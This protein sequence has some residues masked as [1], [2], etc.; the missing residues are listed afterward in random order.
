MFFFVFFLWVFCMCEISAQ[1]IPGGLPALPDLPN[2]DA[3][4]IDESGEVSPSSQEMSWQDIWDKYFQNKF[5]TS[6]SMGEVVDRTSITNVLRARVPFSDDLKVTFSAEYYYSHI[7]AVLKK[8]DYVEGDVPDEIKVDTEQEELNVREAYFDWSFHDRASLSLGRQTLAWGQFPL[9][10]P[11][12]Y[13]LPWRSSLQSASANKADK[14]VPLD[15]AVL[16]LYPLGGIE[17]SLFYFNEFRY[18]PAVKE[19]IGDIYSYIHLP[20]DSKLDLGFKEP[21]DPFYAVRVASN[22]SWG[23]VILTYMHGYEQYPTRL[24]KVKTVNYDIDS[25]GIL[26]ENDKF[27]TAEGDYQFYKRDLLGF[28]ASIPFWGNYTFRSEIVYFQ[29]IVDGAPYGGWLRT[30]DGVLDY[31]NWLNANN[32]SKMYF[33][34]DNTIYAAGVDAVYDRWS[35][36]LYLYTMNSQL[37]EEHEEGHKLYEK[38]A[39]HEDDTSISNVAP[40]LQVARKCL[41]DKNLVLG[42][43]AGALEQGA[44][45]SLYC[46]HNYNDNINWGLSFDVIEYWIDGLGDHQDYEK[47]SLDFS[48]KFGIEITV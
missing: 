45:G 18:D 32:D 25:D 27:Y 44:G 20:D 2:L 39:G 1:D 35:W 29:G 26:G 28:E 16:S 14:H 48:V 42:V 38:A 9:F 47:D 33:L 13:S 8:K 23:T 40:A 17:V 22:Q 15:V 3:V 10:S 7:E 5:F 30:D 24:T 11:V 36:S 31:I 19:S 4:E 34:S 43:V 21:E 6:Y 46:V 12:D 37:A 41:K